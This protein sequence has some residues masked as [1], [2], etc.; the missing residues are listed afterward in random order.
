MTM[1]ASAAKQPSLGERRFNLEKALGPNWKVKFDL[2]VHLKPDQ[3]TSLGL[4]AILTEIA[5]KMKIDLVQTIDHVQGVQTWAEVPGYLVVAKSVESKQLLLAISEM[6]ISE[7]VDSEERQIRFEVVDAIQTVES[8]IFEEKERKRAQ[9]LRVSIFGLP[10]QV[11]DESLNRKMIEFGTPTNIYR[12]KMA[13]PFKTIE[14]GIRHVFFKIPLL[15]T[16]PSVIYVEGTKCHPQY[17]GQKEQLK[18]F[19]CKNTGHFAKQCKEPCGKCGVQGHGAW[20]CKSVTVP[21]VSVQ[22]PPVQLE[23]RNEFPDLAGAAASPV[24]ATPPE[25]NTTEESAKESADERTNRIDTM[26]S[27]I[28]R[29]V[30][31]DTLNQVEQASDTSGEFFRPGKQKRKKESPTGNNPAKKTLSKSNDDGSSSHRSNRR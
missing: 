23:D 2:S 10:G 7:K 20:G 3:K 19:N 16:I 1:A 26:M 13:E 14:N 6:I 11:S 22:A 27:N 15:K 25:Q 30:S 29:S 31:Q 5:T 24:F 9:T 8:L 28:Q 12:C 21:A 4:P 18:C 17:A